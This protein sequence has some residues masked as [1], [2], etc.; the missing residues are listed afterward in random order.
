MLSRRGYLVRFER[1]RSRCADCCRGSLTRRKK[2][3]EH[4]QQDDS[5]CYETFGGKE[6]SLAAMQ[7][8]APKKG[9]GDRRGG[10]E[11]RLT[12]S[13]KIG[14]FRTPVASQ[15]LARQCAAKRPTRSCF[16]TIKRHD[17]ERRVPPSV[18]VP[19]YVYCPNGK[20]FGIVYTV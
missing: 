2:P 14:K 4:A 8:P 6:F 10:D 3:C 16:P 11:P 17:L 7:K 9:L 19:W 20:I 13:M 15:D 1:Q 18:R 5:E 12:R